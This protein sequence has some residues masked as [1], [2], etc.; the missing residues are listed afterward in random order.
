MSCQEPPKKKSERNNGVFC[1]YSEFTCVDAMYFVPV[2]TSAY[3]MKKQKTE[4]GS[5]PYIRVFLHECMR[6]IKYAPPQDTLEH[7][8]WRK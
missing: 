2:R 5:E 4:K 3:H 6:N 7:T 1:V 8:T